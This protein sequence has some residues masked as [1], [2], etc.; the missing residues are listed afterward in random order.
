MAG[1]PSKTEQPTVDR[2][3]DSML[4]IVHT[5]GGASASV[6][7]IARGAGVTEAVLYR[8][9]PSKEAMFH[10]VWYRRLQPM[11]HAKV[12]LLEQADLSPEQV[13]TDWVRLTFREY[14]ADPAAFFFVF[15]S[16]DNGPWRRD[17]RLFRMQSDAFQNWITRDLSGALTGPI[18]AAGMTRQIAAILLSVPRSIKA[19]RLE[20][21]AIN[22]LDSTIES[23]RR[24]LQLS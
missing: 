11:V 6:R 13:L 9:F 1:P 22:H 3:I 18:S 2:L 8:Y 16:E 24:L 17:D 15:L 20:A 10:E 5:S 23:I 19:G 4:Q 12:A 7:A 14:D 21:P